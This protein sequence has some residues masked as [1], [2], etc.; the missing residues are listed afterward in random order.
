VPELERIQR[1]HPEVIGC[2]HGLGLVGGL[3][4]VRPGTK[5]PDSV[6]AQR[7]NEKC[8]HKG[9]LLFAPA[10]V[11]GECIKIAPPL[12]TTEEA[13]R[14]GIATLEEACDEVVAQS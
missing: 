13:L 3:Q 8:F 1:K 14:E 11:G 4:I 10:G 9:L 6:T 5:T 2:A 7:I 12:V